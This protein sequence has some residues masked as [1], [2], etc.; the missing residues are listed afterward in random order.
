MGRLQAAAQP[1]K[2]GLEVAADWGFL[3]CTSVS[4]AS[5]EASN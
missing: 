5:N 1:P 3:I 4:L 2:P